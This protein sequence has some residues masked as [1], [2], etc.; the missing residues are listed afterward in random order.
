MDNLPTKKSWQIGIVSAI[1][2]L[3][4]VYVYFIAPPNDFPKNT[5]FTVPDGVGLDQLA[6]QLKDKHFIRSAVWFRIAGIT[7]GGER[8]MK[9]GDYFFSTEESVFTVAYRIASAQHNIETVKITIPEG[10]TNKEISDL[11][12]IKFLKFN[13]AEFLILAPQ[14]YLF[15]DTYFIEVGATASSTI[16]LLRNNFDTKISKLNMDIKT[17]GHSLNDLITTASI[18]ESEVRTDVD[19]KLVSGILWK[20]IKIGMALQVDS[21]PETYDHRG[22]PTSPVS[23]PGIESIKAAIYPTASS[24]LYFLTDKSGNVHYAKTFDEHQRNRELY[25][26]K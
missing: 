8:G 17:S 1:T 3:V 16:K 26:N 21:A 25:L 24:Y 4:L 14:G 22:L 6:L 7:A 13:H 15:P 5:I 19:R 10:F 23:N 9:A 2:I 18:I 12:N 20:R 11:F